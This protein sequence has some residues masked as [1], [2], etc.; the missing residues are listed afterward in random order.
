MPPRSSVAAP[1]QAAHADDSIERIL[2]ENPIRRIWR[3][4]YLIQCFAD[5]FYANI[6]REHG[7]SRTEITALHCLAQSGPLRAQDIV[8]MLV[9]PKNTVSGAV[10]ALL[11][12]HLIRRRPNPDDARGAILTL[13]ET[14]RKLYDQLLPA[15]MERERLLL[16]SLDA[17]ELAQLDGLLE[18]LVRD[19]RNWRFPGAQPYGSGL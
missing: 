6:E 2:H 15:L 1:K 17:A 3:I 19:V 5:P 12:R 10:H 4:S 8:A 7:L 11:R 14:G 18:K 13:S 9:R 16:N